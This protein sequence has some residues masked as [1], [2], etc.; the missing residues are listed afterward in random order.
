MR[1]KYARRF[2]EAE[3]QGLKCVLLYCG[4]H[5]PDGLRISDFLRSNLEQLMD[6]EWKDGTEG[7]DP[8]SLII[9]R[10]GLDYDFIEE[11][12][13]TWINNLITGSKKN[14]A[15]PEHKNHFMPYVQEYLET[16]GPRKCE[17][18]SIVKRKEKGRKL[19]EDSILKYL[20]KDATSRFDR[21]K[22]EAIKEMD[23]FRER[24]GLKEAIEAAQKLI[25]DEE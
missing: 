13:L 19:C 24:T 8:S 18:N 6:I 17:A 2:Q 20:G 25:E 14:L 10:F 12:D 5:D 21:R 4:D 1:A 9:E 7:Y 11:N 22:A 3:E 16:Y 23:E 15:S